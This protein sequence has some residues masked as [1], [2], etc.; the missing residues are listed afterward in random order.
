MESGYRV[1]DSGSLGFELQIL[2][3]LLNSQYNFK[4]C[5]IS[6]NV[7]STLR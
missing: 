6:S 2:V 7:K 3:N 4:M 1:I 5:V